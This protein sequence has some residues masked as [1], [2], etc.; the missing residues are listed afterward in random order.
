[1]NLYQ[2]VWLALA[3]IIFKY[4]MAFG[5]VVGV[6]SCL[7]VDQKTF[8]RPSV[9]AL[10]I[11]AIFWTDIFCDQW[12]FAYYYIGVVVGALDLPT[13]YGDPCVGFFALEADQEI[14]ED[15]YRTAKCNGRL[16]GKWFYK[17]D[18]F[19]GIQVSVA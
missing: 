15:F 12:A 14:T 11:F 17:D 8:I 19:F 6:M 13:E 9:P 4:S 5:L 3:T 10:L 7:A 16:E 1:M 18:V 2:F